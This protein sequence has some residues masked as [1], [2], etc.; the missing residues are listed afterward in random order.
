[1]NSIV[2]CGGGTAGHVMPNIALLKYLKQHFDIDV[3]PV[4]R[5][6]NKGC[7]GIRFYGMKKNPSLSFV[8]VLLDFIFN[9]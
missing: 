8:E 9:G 5:G 2:L 6:V 7:Y 3:T 1:M 4:T